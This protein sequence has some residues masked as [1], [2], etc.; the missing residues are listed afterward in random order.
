MSLRY[1]KTKLHLARSQVH[2]TYVLTISISS[3]RGHPTGPDLA[4]ISA[5]RRRGF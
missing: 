3:G 1:P 2:L 5:H 4:Q